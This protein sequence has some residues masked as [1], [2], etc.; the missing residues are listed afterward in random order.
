MPEGCKLV[1]PRTSLRCRTLL[2]CLHELPA[3]GLGM[4]GVF[5]T[6]TD[7]SV[8]KTVSAACL[9]RAWRAG[10]WKPV[11]TG[12]E[13]GDDDADAVTDAVTALAAAPADRIVTPTYALR[14]PLSPHAAAELE[15]AHIDLGAI[16]LPQT[17]CPLV[18]E[19]AGG[20][21]TSIVLSR[22]FKVV[23]GL[24]VH[25]IVRSRNSGY[26]GRTEGAGIGPLSATR[27]G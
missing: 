15:G 12:T 10:Y 23:P 26:R 13:I 3:A 8:G 22:A 9:V 24:A 7:T 6:G 1:F 25:G 5:V 18:V 14:A 2:G 21:V 27:L 17:E 4:T 16:A 11:Q 19:G 20:M